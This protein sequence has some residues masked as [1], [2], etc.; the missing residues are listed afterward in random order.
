M[1]TTDSDFEK[2]VIQA[3]NEKPVLVDFWAPWCGP[4]LMLGPIME[5]V[6]EDYKD[7]VVLVKINVE[8]NQQTSSKYNILSI[9]NVKLFKNG[10]PVNEFVGVKS[11]AD[12]KEWIDSNL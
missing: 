6:A 4:C 8:E 1:E 12:I 7:K 3:S 11:E 10:N 5:K 9:P 2:D